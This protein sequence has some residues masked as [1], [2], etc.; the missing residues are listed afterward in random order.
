MINYLSRVLE[1]TVK[2]QFRRY[3]RLQ[4]WFKGVEQYYHRALHTLYHIYISSIII[5][6]KLNV[7]FKL[8]PS[9]NTGKW[10]VVSVACGRVKSSHR[11]FTWPLRE[12]IKIRQHLN[13]ARTATHPQHQSGNDFQ[14]HAPERRTWLKEFWTQST[15]DKVGSV[16]TDRGGVKFLLAGREEGKP[17]KV[18]FENNREDLRSAREPWVGAWQM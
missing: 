10:S 7:N 17:L 2:C 5:T 12:R 9:W 15:V 11:L 14:L 13:A 6:Y 18:S 1:S 4:S 16:D 8:Q 3:V